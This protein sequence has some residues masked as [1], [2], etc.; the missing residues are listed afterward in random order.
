MSYAAAAAWSGEHSPSAKQTSGVPSPQPQDLC[1]PFMSDKNTRKLRES[2]SLRGS[3]LLGVKVRAAAEW[4]EK[5]ETRDLQVVEKN[6][7]LF[8]GHLGREPVK[9][10]LGPGSQPEPTG[11]QTT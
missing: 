11:L 8:G 9:S 3:R 5:R 7:G 2:L 4:M 6:R 1:A 10:L